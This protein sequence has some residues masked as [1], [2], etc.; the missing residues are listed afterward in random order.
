MTALSFAFGLAA[1]VALRVCIMQVGIAAG[2][3]INLLNGRIVCKIG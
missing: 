2:S 1:V 3:S